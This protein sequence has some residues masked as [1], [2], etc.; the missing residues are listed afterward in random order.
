MKKYEGGI[1]MAM[2]LSLCLVFTGC[3][4][5]STK[6]SMGRTIDMHGLSSQQLLKEGVP[7][8]GELTTEE[9]DRQLMAM[10]ETI[11]TYYRLSTINIW[12]YWFESD[13]LIYLNL[14]YY[15]NLQSFAKNCEAY[16][17]R[18]DTE[19]Q[20]NKLKRWKMMH[21]YMVTFWKW[22]VG[23]ESSVE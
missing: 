1:L 18:L 23:E 8:P 11:D 20:E 6:T 12:A 7:A 13:K 10:T 15:K 17:K 22:R 4:N 16:A 3:G 19:S 9:L 14:D 2:I 5:I 21:Q